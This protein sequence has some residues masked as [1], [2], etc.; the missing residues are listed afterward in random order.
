MGADQGRLEEGVEHIL[1][2]ALHN[3]GLDHT[4]GGNTAKAQYSH[5]VSEEFLLEN[6]HPSTVGDEDKLQQVSKH[7]LLGNC[8]GGG[9]C[10]LDHIGGGNNGK[11]KKK[12]GWR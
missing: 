2:N 1:L 4:D 3:G 6:I 11:S 9:D 8:G 7:V 10:V 12:R 5:V